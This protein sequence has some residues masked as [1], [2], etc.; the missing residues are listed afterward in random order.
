[1]TQIERERA[2]YATSFKVIGRGII[3]SDGMSEIASPPDLQCRLFR[4]EKVRLQHGGRGFVLTHKGSRLRC[5][6]RLGISVYARDQKFHVYIFS[7]PFC[8]S[9][10]F[11][12]VA[13]F[14]QC[15]YINHAGAG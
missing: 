14:G 9:G 6:L 4:A 15:S 11:F 2:L 7:G 13:G 12:W 3:Y 10:I 1:M 5:I 8:Q